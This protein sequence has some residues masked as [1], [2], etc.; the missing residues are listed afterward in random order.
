MPISERFEYEHIRQ[1]LKG[2]DTT[3]MEKYLFAFWKQTAPTDT[4]IEWY[5]YKKQDAKADQLLGNS[6]QVGC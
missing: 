4:D 1:L 5:K 6:K 3:N 2:T